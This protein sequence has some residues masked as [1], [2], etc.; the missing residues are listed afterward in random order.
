VAQARAILGDA[1]LRFVIT[2]G[3]D[4]RT[5]AHLS[6]RASA[7]QRT[8]LLFRHDE[9]AVSGCTTRLA[10]QHD[11]DDPWAR[12]LET[13]LP[14]LKPVCPHHHRRKTAG[15]WDWVVEP[16]DPLTGKHRL[17]PR[18]HPDHPANT[19]A[20]KPSSPARTPVRPRPSERAPRV[21][22][23]RVLRSRPPAGVSVSSDGERPPPSTQ[24]G[25]P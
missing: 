25:D 14:N 22:R 10:L 13:W 15:G 18:H 7:H 11:H 2:D 20:V 23:L 8:A 19:G 24:E 3:H 17:V 4:V 12:T 16:P 9:C 21:R 1:L 5:V 6:R